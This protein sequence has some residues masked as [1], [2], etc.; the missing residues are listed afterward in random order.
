VITTSARS[1]GTPALVRPLTGLRRRG[2]RLGPVRI[3]ADLAA[4]HPQAAFVAGASLLVGTGVVVLL[5]VSSI[6]AFMVL[7]GQSTLLADRGTAALALQ[8]ATGSGEQAAATRAP[9]PVAGSGAAH[10]T[11]PVG[12]DEVVSI[13][14]IRVHVSIAE[15]V[16]ALLDAAAADG[17]A[18]SGWGWRDSQAQVRLRRQHCG[19]SQYAIYQMPSGQCSPPTARPGSSQHER[20]LAIDFTYAGGSIGSHR[21]VGYRWL[22][23]NAAT[24]GLKNL[25]SEPWHW[26]TT[27]R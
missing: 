5:I 11:A 16:Q 15:D 7:S 13:E 2:A 26:S 21:N 14:G 4:R 25:P 12:K 6:Q 18:L 9:A 24:Y 17:I 1:V 20:G 27:G 19:T 8:A 3:A 23:A 22:A 10:P